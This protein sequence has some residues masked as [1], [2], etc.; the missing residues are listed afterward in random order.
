MSLWM[1]WLLFAT[2]WAVGLI[3]WM[4]VQINAEAER[5]D[6]GESWDEFSQRVQDL[7]R[8]PAN[9]QPFDPHADARDYRPA[10]ES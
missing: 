7:L 10:A 2:A 5:C 9:D 6:D 8:E 1:I 4:L 3:G